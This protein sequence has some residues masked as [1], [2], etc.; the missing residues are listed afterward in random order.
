MVQDPADDFLGHVT[1]DQ[2][3]AECM[4][5][6]VRDDADGLGVLV[7]D[8]AALEPAVKRLPV[9]AAIRGPVS[10]GI[11]FRHREQHPRARRPPGLQIETVFTDGA[12]QF[13][14]DRDQR[15]A[16]HLV[17]VVAQVGRSVAVMDDA[18][19]WQADRVGDPQPA[20]HQDEGDQPVVG[21]V[22]SGEVVGVF[23]L[24]HHGFADGCC[25][26]RCLHMSRR[27]SMCTGRHGVGDR[28]CWLGVMVSPG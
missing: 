14:V 1:V 4:P 6:T 22:P 23:E 16:V 7:T 3:G 9:G 25:R 17:V 26:P 5:E 28:L 13:L 27:R 15:F 10:L 21:V 19:A 18:V 8:V 24:G 11:V 12:L 2:P 20:A